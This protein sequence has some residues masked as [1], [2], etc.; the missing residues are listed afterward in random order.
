MN[1]HWRMF[2]VAAALVGSAALPKQG[3]AQKQTGWVNFQIHGSVMSPQTLA[4]GR[5]F[6]FNGVTFAR[7]LDL[8]LDNTGGIGAGL[9]FWFGGPRMFGLLLEGTYSGWSG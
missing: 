2:T 8:G 3:S 1:R 6:T 5:S 9:D 4:E 7:G